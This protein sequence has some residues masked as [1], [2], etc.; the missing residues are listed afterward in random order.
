M[1][2]ASLI[3]SLWIALT[4]LFGFLYQQPQSPLQQAGIQASS[5]VQTIAEG[6]SSTDATP[7][8]VVASVTSSSSSQQPQQA[9]SQSSA[10][11][12]TDASLPN[13]SPWEST[14]ALGDYKYTTGSPQKGYIY[15]C[16][17]VQGGS[18]AQGTA[19]WISG[20]VWYPSE[21][22]SVEGDVPWPSA[23]FSSV[24]SGDMR[25]LKG[26][27]LPTDHDTGTFPIQSSDP[28]HQFDGNPNSIKAQSDDYTLPVTPIALSQPD[29]IYGQ[30]GVMNDGVALFD[31]F[32][33]E[34]RDAVAHE[35]QDQWDGHP[36]VTSEYHDHGFETGPVKDP[37]STVVGFAFDGYPITGSLLPNGN[38][39]HTTDLDECHGLTSTITL[40]GKSVTTYHY[41]LTQDFPYSVSCFHGRSYEPLPG[42]GTANQ[43]GGSQDDRN[44]SKADRKPEVCRPRRRRPPSP[45][46]P[47]KRAARPVRSRPPTE[48]FPARVEHRRANRRSPAFPPN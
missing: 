37:I 4:G 30:V 41:V 16:H 9:S 47:R 29:C 2:L 7:S 36:D 11:V 24:V 15:V 6:P 39:L 8:A 28:A 32:D 48:L 19:T 45:P 18:G 13:G 22:V 27:D 35:V 5:T 12:V 1:G 10:S 26:N 3:A 43:T 20:D 31:G 46:V 40:D 42:E 33:A 34:Y 38:Y 23:S 21:K 17:V 25:I 14:L 44:R